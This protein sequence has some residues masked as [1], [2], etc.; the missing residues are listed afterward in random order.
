MRQFGYERAHILLVDGI[1]VAIHK[2]IRE[3]SPKAKFKAARVGDF[4]E[5]VS[6]INQIL[7]EASTPTHW[8]SRCKR[9][10]DRSASVRS[11]WTLETLAFS[12]GQMSIDV[13]RY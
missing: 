6:S 4:A 9:C 7:F 3:M 1:A 10:A 12:S 2:V 11:D 13:C 5:D 8:Y